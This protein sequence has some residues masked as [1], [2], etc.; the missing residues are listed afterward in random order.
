VC[1]STVSTARTFQKVEAALAKG[2][3]KVARA[4]AT[5]GIPAST[6][7]SKITQ[8]GIEKRRFTTAW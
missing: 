4:A 2:R 3:G 1:A 5:L 7:E 6:L 8:L